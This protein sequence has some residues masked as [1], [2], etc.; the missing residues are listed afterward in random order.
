[1]V[2]YELDEISP[3]MENLEISDALLKLDEYSEARKSLIEGKALGSEGFASEV[4][5]YCDLDNNILCV[6]LEN[7]KHMDYANKLLVGEKP[8]QWSKSDTKPL[9]KSGDLSLTDNCRG[10]AL[11]SKATRLVNR[12]ILNRIRPKINPHHRPNQN[13]F[14]PGKLTNAHILALRRLIEGVKL[15][16]LKAVLI[17]VDFSKSFDSIHRGRMFCI[18]RAYDVPDKIFQAIG[19]MYD[20]AHARVLTPDRNTDY[21]EILAGLLKDNTIAPILSAIVLFANETSH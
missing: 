12:M 17:F 10:I 20:G 4:L 14:R 8:N 9:L 21:F 1:M 11:S 16:I 13:G 7:I 15:H 2:A 18:M 3:E 5:K 19:L 6:I